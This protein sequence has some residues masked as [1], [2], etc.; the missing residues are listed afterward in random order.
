MPRRMI[1]VKAHG[2]FRNT[3]RLLEAITHAHYERILNSYGKRG[4]E[5]LANATPVDT[6]KTAASWGYEINID[7]SK[8]Q[9]S[10]TFTN[11]NIKDG[12]ANIAIMIQY[13]HG[14][15]NGGFVKGRNY[16][17]PAIRPI[18]DEMANEVWSEVTK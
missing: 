5:A 3:D 7:K 18:F 17:N 11:S 2:N 15:R 12:W 10:I 9:F 14:T 16:I 1:V 4:V 6:G 8:G 13:G